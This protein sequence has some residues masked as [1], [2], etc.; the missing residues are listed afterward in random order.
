MD[1]PYTRDELSAIGS[2]AKP[3]RGRYCPKCKSHVPEFADISPELAATFKGMHAAK[4]MAAICDL[5][6]CPLGWAK[7][8]VIHKDGPHREYG[9]TDAPPCPYCGNQLRTRLAKQC[10]ECGAD[11]HADARD[12]E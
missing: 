4:A 7:S 6:G 5:T 1:A 8:W 9:D 2:G 12:Q 11:W 3:T 10:V